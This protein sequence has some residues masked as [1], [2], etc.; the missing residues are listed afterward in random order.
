[1]RSRRSPGSARRLLAGVE[2]AENIPATERTATSRCAG[3]SIAP[4]AAPLAEGL[5]GLTVRRSRATVVAVAEHRP[6]PIGCA[7]RRPTD[8]AQRSR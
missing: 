5:T 1:M 2:I 8:G 6:S 3:P 7:G 4:R